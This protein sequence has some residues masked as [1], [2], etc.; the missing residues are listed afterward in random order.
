MKKSHR[1]ECPMCG[2]L[3]VL[4]YNAYGTDLHCDC[5]HTFEAEDHEVGGGIGA[6]QEQIC[7]IYGISYED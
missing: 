2:Q 4:A 3:K 1:Y 7:D 5:G 6:L